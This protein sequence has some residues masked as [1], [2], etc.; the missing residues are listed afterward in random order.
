MGACDRTNIHERTH[1]FTAHIYIRFYMYV[2]ANDNRINSMQ[3]QAKTTI[4]GELKATHSRSPSS[5]SGPY[6]SNISH[7]N[8]IEA[9]GE[10]RRQQHTE[11]IIAVSP[12]ANALRERK[13]AQETSKIEINKK[14]ATFSCGYKKLTRLLFSRRIECGSADNVLIG[15]NNRNAAMSMGKQLDGEV[16]WALSKGSAQFAGEVDVWRCCCLPQKWMAVSG[17][18][19][20]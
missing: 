18:L 4:A 16:Q 20:V 5:R 17:R 8:W 1:L 9:R 13:K 10:A 12:N 19:A 6:N 2:C 15:Q 14:C 11:S 7:N 3:F